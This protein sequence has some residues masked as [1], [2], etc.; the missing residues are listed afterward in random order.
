MKCSLVTFKDKTE[1]LK[2]SHQSPDTKVT[3][4]PPYTR[5]RQLSLGF[6]CTCQGVKCDGRTDCCVEDELVEGW[7]VPVE[8]DEPRE[9]SLGGDREGPR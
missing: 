3:F 5:L 7:L 6:R 9:V 4:C 1:N 2:L 8:G